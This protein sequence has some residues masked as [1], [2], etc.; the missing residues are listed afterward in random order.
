MRIAL[1]R[2]VGLAHSEEGRYRREWFFA[3]AMISKDM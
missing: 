3:V 2:A 1:S